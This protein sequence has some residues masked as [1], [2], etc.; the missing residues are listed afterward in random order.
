MFSQK[1][2]V[3]LLNIKQRHT[4]TSIQ[5]EF[6]IKIG[7]RL[8]FVR[9]YLWLIIKIYIY[10]NIQLAYA[11]FRQHIHKE[12]HAIMHMSLQSVFLSEINED[13]KKIFLLSD[14]CPGQNRNKTMSRFLIIAAVINRIDI[15]HLFPVRGHSYCQCNRNF[16]LN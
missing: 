1:Y 11:T 16:G 10:V 15:L 12:Q 4:S 8:L 5:A 14:A 2:K 6:E 13:T 9:L 7:N 3:K